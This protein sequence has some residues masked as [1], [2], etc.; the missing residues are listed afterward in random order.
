MSTLKPINKSYIL[1]TLCESNFYKL[2]TL[3]PNLLGFDEISSARAAGRPTLY[4]QILE[5]NPYTLTMELTHRFSEENTGIIE[6]AVKI[7]V[8]L[9]T[10]S[11]EVLRNTFHPQV[12]HAF[13][14]NPSPETI[15]DYKWTI[16]YFLEKWLDH[17][18]EQGYRFNQNETVESLDLMF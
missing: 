7:R 12:T 11:A 13:K 14:K 16:N 4:I 1:Q 8:Y 18:I 2:F 6:P 15:L 5:R 3:A 17:C 10:K 9:D